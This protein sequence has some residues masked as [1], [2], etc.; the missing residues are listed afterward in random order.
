M[1]TMPRTL[2]IVVP[3][4]A[5]AVNAFVA[6]KS[7]ADIAQDTA[8][9]RLRV[10]QV[11]REAI[12][13]LAALKVPDQPQPKAPCENCGELVGDAHCDEWSAD[14]RDGDPYFC[15]RKTVESV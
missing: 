8:S 3:R 14:L 4:K 2:R 15:E 11:I 1:V 9:H 5:D 12:I 10:E 13:G 6:G 7:I